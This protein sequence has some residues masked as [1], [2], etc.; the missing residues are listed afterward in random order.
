[1]E[2]LSALATFLILLISLSP[3]PTTATAN[4]SMVLDT[5]GN[6]LVAG[7][8][9][10]VVPATKSPIQ[11]GLTMF[12]N[13]SPTCPE[14][15]VSQSKLGP[16]DLGIPLVFFPDDPE[17]THVQHGS[18]AY[19][20]AFKYL[21]I[22]PKCYRLYT[23]I[24][25]VSAETPSNN[26]FVVLDGGKGDEISFFKIK[27]SDDNNGYIIRYINS[28]NLGDSVSKDIGIVSNEQGVN[29]L[30]LSD[31]AIPLVVVFVKAA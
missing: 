20:I 30:S 25:S 29:L 2:H 31:C 12:N 28:S 19:N 23:T 10:N 27:K 8:F 13:D 16:R 6:P 15:I 14:F 9:Y 22:L 4:D 11:G 17:Q 7:R 3:K 18:S 24:W 1:M 5:K 21:S 26:A